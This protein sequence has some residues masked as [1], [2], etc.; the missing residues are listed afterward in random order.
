MSLCFFFFFFR[1]EETSLLSL[2]SL[3][4]SLCADLESEFAAALPVVPVCLEGPASLTWAEAGAG[5]AASLTCEGA[6]EGAELGVG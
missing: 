2:C 3:F 4:V 1:L 6:A 5:A